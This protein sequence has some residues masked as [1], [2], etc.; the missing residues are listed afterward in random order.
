MVSGKPGIKRSGLPIV[1]A[2]APS[3]KSLEPTRHKPRA[4][5]ARAFSSKMGGLP[6]P[7]QVKKVVRLFVASPGDV[8]SERDQLETVVKEIN[9]KS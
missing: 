7:Q 9:T 6:M 4:A 3:N 5:Q 1:L 8:Q 2:K